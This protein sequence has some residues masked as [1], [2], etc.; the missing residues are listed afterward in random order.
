MNSITKN[1]ILTRPNCDGICAAAICM[2][3]IADRGPN[4]PYIHFVQPYT[5]N[6][7]LSNVTWDKSTTHLHIFD[8]GLNDAVIPLLDG[9]KEITYIDHHRGSEKYSTMFNGLHSTYISSSMLAAQWFNYEGILGPL[10]SVCDKMNYL[11]K[12]DPLLEEANL[13]RAALHTIPDID[14]WTKTVHHLSHGCMPS[15]IPAVVA[16]GN[17]AY[18]SRERYLNIGRDNIQYNK[19]II[20]TDLGHNAGGYGGLVAT[21]LSIEFNKP[22]FAV[23]SEDDSDKYIIVARAPNNHPVDLSVIM[24][25]FGGG[26]HSHAAAGSFFNPEHNFNNVLAAILKINRCN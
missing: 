26:G 8:I 2:A 14:F 4:Y 9:Y 6:D 18:A 23:Y 5:L 17:I 20:V 1:I 12:E 19:E 7:I 21:R 25:R 10:G 16:K 15:K 13:L 24:S 22:A 11:Q 3:A